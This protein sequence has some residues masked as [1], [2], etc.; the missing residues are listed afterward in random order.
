MLTM[1]AMTLGMWMEDPGSLSSGNSRWLMFFVGLVAFCML[2]QAVVVVAF[3]LAALKSQ[4]RMLAIA[5]EV[6]AR[7]VP[8]L[9]SAEEKLFHDSAPKLLSHDRQSA[10]RRAILFERRRWSSMRRSRM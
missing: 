4:K 9:K 6:R 3:V 1:H 8:V 10:R 2:I 7:A 5:E